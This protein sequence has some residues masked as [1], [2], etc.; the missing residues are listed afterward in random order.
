MHAQNPKENPVHEESKAMERKVVVSLHEDG[1][2]QPLHGDGKENTMEYSCDWKNG[3][4]G[5]WREWEIASLPTRCEEEAF[6]GGVGIWARTDSPT[7]PT[8]T[9]Q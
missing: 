3:V 2:I 7:T 9:Q 5:E 8:T 6:S 1:P 4:V